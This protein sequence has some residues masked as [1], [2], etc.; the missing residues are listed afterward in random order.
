MTPSE[1]EWLRREG[2]EFQRQLA[3]KAQAPAVR[4]AKNSQSP[5][6]TAAALHDVSSDEA[7]TFLQK[8]FGAAAEWRS[9]LL[10][11]RLSSDF[12]KDWREEVGHWLKTAEAHG[13]L[14][15]LLNRV[16]KRAKRGTRSTGVDPTTDGTASLSPSSPLPWWRTI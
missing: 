15:P 11:Y 7:L 10:S 1:V 2:T 8:Q 5:T 9:G 13:Y 14:K 16:L 6:V 12:Q 3:S 4:N